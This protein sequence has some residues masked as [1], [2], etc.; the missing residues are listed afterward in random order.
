MQQPLSTRR[1]RPLG[2]SLVIVLVVVL[3]AAILAS[4]AA[5]DPPAKYEGTFEADS[6][7]TNACDFEV[8]VHGTVEYTEIDFVDASGTLTRIF[9]H[10]VEQDAFTANG[11]TLVGIPFTFNIE[12]L[13]DSSGNMTRN[14]ATGI[15]E[16]VP[17]PDGGLFISAGWVDWTAHPG[18]NF[19]LSPNKGNPGNL[20]AFCAALEP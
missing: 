5:A 19:V 6:V 2:K 13:F 11:K 1:G 12:V 8:G 20:A 7:L 4:P 18:T 3:S 9:D 17:L 10:F 15:V 14:V 16:K